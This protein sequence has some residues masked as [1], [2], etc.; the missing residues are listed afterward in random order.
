MEED[1][2]GHVSWPNPTLL[3]V[4]T[5]VERRAVRDNLLDI[6]SG[7]KEVSQN[8]QTVQ[9]LKASPK[10]MSKAQK[11]SAK[12]KRTIAALQ[13]KVDA[14][15]SNS[16]IKQNA[17][18]TTSDKMCSHGKKCWLK[19][20]KYKHE[21]G[22]RPAQ[23]PKTIKC[24]TCERMGHSAAQ[25]GKCYRCGSSDH[26]YRACPERT[27]KVLSQNSQQVLPS[28]PSVEEEEQGVL[29]RL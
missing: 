6:V 26:S 4:R 11:S 8:D 3:E 5:I 1:R 17:A 10:K 21:K 25:C 7:G 19:D 22:H 20:C 29:M 13:Q 16:T 9:S 2:H 27:N 23:D 24:G 18:T 12:D 15:S 28:T 14:Q